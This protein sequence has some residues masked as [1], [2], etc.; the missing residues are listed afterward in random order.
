[1]RLK[2]VPPAPESLAT[3]G[4]MQAALPLVPGSEDDCCARLLRRTALHARDDARTWITF[5]R[6][7]ELVDEHDG[8]YTRRRV[9]P[10]PGALA[11]AFER[12][13]FSARELLDA[14]ASAEE[15]LSPTAAFERIEGIVPRWERNKRRTWREDWRER[16]RRLLDWTVLLGLAEETP[17]GYRAVEGNGPRGEER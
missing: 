7:L 11:N 13:V 5:L 2:P 10:E 1:M 8:G 6:A 12:R 15:P 4:E 14:L 17:D 9:D 3:V 16:V